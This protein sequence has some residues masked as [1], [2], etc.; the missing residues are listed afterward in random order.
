[1]KIDR[2]MISAE[3]IIPAPMMSEIKRQEIVQR[4]RLAVWANG[5]VIEKEW[6]I[7]NPVFDKKRE[8]TTTKFLIRPV[9]TD[10]EVDF[11]VK[12]LGIEL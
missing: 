10:D 1:M 7:H 2:N 11:I 3:C 8:K 6:R 4:N 5:C 12:Q 9:K